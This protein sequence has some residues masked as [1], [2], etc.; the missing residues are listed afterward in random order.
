MRRSRPTAITHTPIETAVMRHIRQLH[1][2]REIAI[3]S[4]IPLLTPPWLRR[5]CEHYARVAVANSNKRQLAR[6]VY[7]WQRRPLDPKQHPGARVPRGRR[8]APKA[9]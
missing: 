1:E 3:A 9:R 8:N 2:K 5:H 7:P 6:T 4:T